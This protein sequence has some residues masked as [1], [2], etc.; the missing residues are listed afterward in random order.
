MAYF[1]NKWNR[2][3]SPLLSFFPILTMHFLMQKV[4]ASISSLEMIVGGRNSDASENAVQI[5]EPVL[6]QAGMEGHEPART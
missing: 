1:P 5:E 4:F 6:E 2:N 3:G